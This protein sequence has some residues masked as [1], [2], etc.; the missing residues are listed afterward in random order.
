MIFAISYYILHDLEGNK[1]FQINTPI[2]NNSLITWI[3]Y[4]IIVF[5]TVGFG[6]IT[7]IGTLTIIFTILEITLHYI[8]IIFGASLLF[9]SSDMNDNI[10]TSE[11]KSYLKKRE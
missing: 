7:P 4:S 2:T 9:Q 10:I 1:A 3:Y 11:L 6:D 8:Y 5:S